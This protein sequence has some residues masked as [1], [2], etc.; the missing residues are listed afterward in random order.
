MAS[1]AL[2]VIASAWSVAFIALF[3]LSFRP[4]RNPD[5]IVTL[6]L[7]ALAVT[8]SGW[9]WYRSR[10]KAESNPSPSQKGH[11]DA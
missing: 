7:F 5:P 6:I 11:P 3:F 1:E 2:K 4:D 9:L 10:K 8:G